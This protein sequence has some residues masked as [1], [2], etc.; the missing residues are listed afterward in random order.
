V[1]KAANGDF[2]GAMTDYAKALELNPKY[3]EVYRNRSI[4]KADMGDI[5]GAMADDNKAIEL[6]PKYMLAYRSRGF[7]HYN[8]REFADSL[9]DFQKYCEL[10]SNASQDYSSFRIWL[11]R[12]RLGEQD[13]ATKE[14]QTYLQNRKAQKPEDWPLKVGRFLAGELPEPDLFKAAEAPDKK[15]DDGRLCDVWFYAGSKRLIEG[16]KTTAMD[17]F[18]KCLATNMKTFQDYL[19]AEAELKYLQ[20]TNG[21]K[22]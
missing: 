8:L 2:D 5:Y 21:T 4:A 9:A 18:A 7:L 1:A 14:L 22:N 16:D 13:S 20:T 19:S 17:Y 11:I 10:G 6:Y 12:A 3:A 15:G